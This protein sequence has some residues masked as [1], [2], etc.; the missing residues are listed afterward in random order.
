MLVMIC[1]QQLKPSEI[2]AYKPKVEL[3]Q[4]IDKS[5]KGD[6][7]NKGLNKYKNILQLLQQRHVR[8]VSIHEEF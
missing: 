1:C 8:V 4:N 5:V 7:L 3:H 6:R 2:L